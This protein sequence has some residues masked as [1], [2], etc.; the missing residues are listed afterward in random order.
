MGRGGEALPALLDENNTCTVQTDTSSAGAR[1]GP[2]QS[3]GHEEQ[4]STFASHRALKTNFRQRPTKREGMAV[5][6]AIKHFRQYAAGS[7]HVA[8]S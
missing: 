1:V 8:V 4:V 6:G 2:L 3:E 5:L 7:A